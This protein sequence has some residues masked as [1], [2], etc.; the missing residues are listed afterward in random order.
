MP[1]YISS[2]TIFYLL[3]DISPVTTF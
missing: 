2:V 3:V 1:L